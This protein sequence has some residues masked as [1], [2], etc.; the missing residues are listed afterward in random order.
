MNAIMNEK[1]RQTKL[2]AAFAIIAMVACV[3]AVA[4]PAEDADASTVTV[5]DGVS[6]EF[7]D[8]L[9]GT[10]DIETSTITVSGVTLPAENSDLV[11]TDE[12]TTFESIFGDNTD[13]DYAFF[14]VNGLAGLVPENGTLTIVQ[15]NAAMNGFYGTGEFTDDTKTKEYKADDVSDG[16]GMLIPKDDE[17]RTVEV[18]IGETK[19]TIDFTDVT[20]VAGTVVKSEAELTAALDDE[21]VS[22][23]L[24]GADFS[25]ANSIR[26]DKTVN[27]Y[28]NGY[29]I[30]ASGSQPWTG[31][32]GTDKILNIVANSYNVGLY[33]L[34][35]DNRNASYGINVYGGTV[36]VDNVTSINSAGAGLII[37]GNA[38]VTVTESS[39]QGAWGGINVDGG[40]VE[41][42]S[43]ENLGSVYSENYADGTTITIA[44]SGVSPVKMT[45]TW[46]A[47]EDSSTSAFGGFYES[48]DD[49][50][51]PYNDSR[52][53]KDS[54]QGG[55]PTI[56]VNNNTVLTTDFNMS[57]GTLT[58]SQNATLV[59]DENVT[60]DVSKATA[61]GEYIASAGSEIA[62]AKE[63]TA[64][65]VAAPGATVTVGGEV[66]KTETAAT[67]S[68]IEDALEIGGYG[69]PVTI[70]EDVTLTE[71]VT[72]PA[73]M[74][75]RMDTGKKITLD[76][77]TLTTNN[78]Q[79]SGIVV[80]DSAE[81]NVVLSGSY[82]IKSGSIEVGGRISG[83]IE[84]VNG[85]A[86][87]SGTIDGD[88]EI[89]GSGSVTFK[90]ATVNSNADITITGSVSD[91]PDITYLIQDKFWLYGGLLI[92]DD[93]TSAT[94]TVDSNSEF[95][96]FGN[97]TIAPSI[98]VVGTDS[99][100]K[101]DLG[102]AMGTQY[103]R[104]DVTS[105]LVYSQTQTVIIEESIF[106]KKSASLTVYGQLIV[107]EGVEVIIEDGGK[108][109]VNN[110]TA[111]VTINGD[112]EVE[113]G[114]AMDI[115]DAD[116][117]DVSGTVIS[118]GELTINSNVTVKNG[119]K[120]Q[121]ENGDASK[122]TISGEGAKL[123]VEVGGNVEIR[124]QAAVSDITNKGTVTLNGAILNG[125]VKISLAADGA[126]VAIKSFTS[127]TT[128]SKLEITDN[129]LIFKDNKDPAKVV[130][131]N[132][133]DANTLTINGQ[134]N[135]GIK[136]LTITESVTSK[137]VNKET[138]YYNSLILSG[139]VTIA[140][141]TA[142]GE[143]ITSV[144]MDVTGPSVDVVDDLT[145]G[146]GVILNL[147]SGNLDVSGTITAT[148]DGATVKATGGDINVSGMIETCVEITTNINAF[149]YEG[150]LDGE[151]VYYYTTL[152]TAIDNGQTDI[153]ALGTTSVLESV[154][155]PA[156]TEIKA[157]PGHEKIIIG[158]SDARD[159]VV[160]VKDGGE[161]RSC[162]IDV[163][164]T[165]TF[166]NKRDD[167]NNTITSDVFVEGDVSKSYTNIYTALNNAESGETV[168][169][170]RSGSNVILDK[171]ITVKEGVTLDIPSGKG[172]SV[173]DN[174]TVTVDGTIKNSGTLDNVKYD[175]ET[176]K[177]VV[178]SGFNPE[179]ENN[180]T[181]VVNGAF[182][183]V[184]D[185]P[186]TD[187]VENGVQG[188]Y[189]PGAYY[190][191]VNTA[192]NWN[193]VTPVE[194]AAAV[195][196]DVTDGDIKIRGTNQVGDVTFTG[197]ED[198]PVIILVEGKLTVSSLKLVYA[199]L[200]V[201][202]N[203]NNYQFDGTITSDAGSIEFINANGFIV[204]STVNDEDETV[205]SL[206]DAPAK[207]DAEG[208]DV[209]V[210]IAS[211]NVSV[212]DSNTNG[213][214]LNVTGTEFVIAETATLTVDGNGAKL[215]A[216]DLTVNGTLVAYDGG[217]VTAEN[218]YV[219][220][221]FTVSPADSD[222]DVQAGSATITGDI[223]VG[224]SDDFET[225][226]A[227][228]LNAEKIGEW[229]NLYV[230]AESTVTED[231]VKSKENTQFFVEDA[232]WFTV[233][234]NSNADRSV[235]TPN[236]IPTDNVLL[237]D[238]TG[239]DVNGNHK[240]I[241]G[242]TE[243]NIN[244][245][246]RFDANINYDIY[247]V[248]VFA[249]P[250][251]TAVYIDGKLMT[252]GYF[253]NPL[254]GTDDVTMAAG[255]QAYVSAGEHE[256]TYKLGNYFSGEA[257]MT[258]NGDAVAGNTFT[259]SG[260]PDKNESGIYESS[261]DYVVYLQ[262][263]NASAPETPS[264]GGSSDDGM[265]LTDYLLIVL[266]VLIVVMA[267]LVA[268]RLMRS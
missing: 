94:V 231:L 185:I 133:E 2:L 189:I 252:S 192:G 196:N 135:G 124:S 119:G 199:N 101:I 4:L 151:T 43:M 235:K 225:T 77:F 11:G 243:F 10:Y 146:K 171:D 191:L 208:A 180:V 234:A 18:T 41:I 7:P 212:L 268:V 86:I 132:A 261:V 253:E 45:G 57:A 112:I 142:S 29:T 5:G 105:N 227:A 266:I 26:I 118:D 34:I 51:A 258:V 144:Q 219:I 52:I 36:V 188:Y 38:N 15:K 224:I 131:V 113:N 217:N 79:F 46:K 211:G 233:Y 68:T 62:F 175:Q 162:I 71:N 197:D 230:S 117:V 13:K 6:F 216:K 154:D 28:G 97:S 140:D 226:S 35:V 159:V 20:T 176:E 254:G 104:Q 181:I 3:F 257:T 59:V 157:G 138:T 220:G 250:G 209:K 65:A 198:Q 48:I 147:T 95:K 32:Q 110:Q 229:D 245:V 67:A 42:D 182:M 121:T 73:G 179:A 50:V 170:Y 109:I 244:E 8:Y 137:T 259:T 19:Y 91:T 66:A 88:L 263:I 44:D 221:T 37:G 247:K 55:L 58:V 240:T 184:E 78:S 127:G 49:A 98:A 178:G 161:F 202:D 186:F 81:V 256:I 27:I 72:I 126:V 100:S 107:N 23:I 156:G 9:T 85:N 108:L 116:A 141:E 16:L 200:K 158:S 228:T 33:D 82:T 215:N 190:N 150:T 262:G 61:T 24:I 64:K 139:S 204:D 87:I 177:Y 115:T 265:G 206:A 143:G 93:K 195:S 238:W 264:T 251:I 168:T 166:D 187:D 47:N 122:F 223:R 155:I 125:D 232:L 102:D 92:A 74:D 248:T 12:K 249:D 136:G 39:M 22:N 30:S 111:K 76:K 237:K 242:N 134:A 153:E 163:M 173:V 70:T 145:I 148:A 129:G 149:S 14:M 172:V 75:I 222:S 246:E 106:I 160:T 40:T 239:T 218:V 183:S 214:D 164:G 152:K 80:G 130:K 17:S 25:I 56:T 84:M 203:E 69:V 213:N 114:G 96:A 120:I 201:V 90:D 1:G 89:S 210:T 255:F 123:T 60:L 21:T 103:I 174:V 260:M 236:V 83:S 167:R 63:S 169:I 241:D 267:I 194:D 128:A 205:M 31:S 165:L 53:V 54:E 207:A 99:T 193:Y